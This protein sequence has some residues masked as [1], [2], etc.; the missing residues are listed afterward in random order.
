MSRVLIVVTAT[1]LLS[2][3]PKFASA[4]EEGAAAG[5]VTG[6]IAGA[7]VGGPIGAVVGAVVGGVAL[8]AATGPNTE[9]TQAQAPLPAQPGPRSLVP[10]SPT[11]LVDPETT[12]T[13]VETR[14]CVRDAQGI[15][16]CRRDPV[17]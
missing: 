5:A 7:A 3:A 2:A 15:S 13:V 6:A 8:G 11:V 17:R 14:T 16:R 9:S 12:G 4:A 1:L 10:A